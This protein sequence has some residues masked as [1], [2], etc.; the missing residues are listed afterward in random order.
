MT[1]V[2]ASLKHGAMASDSFVEGSGRVRTKV[3]RG[4]GC[5]AAAS[6]DAYLCNV[7]LRWVQA[8][9]QGGIALVKIDDSPLDGTDFEGLLLERNRILVFG[10]ILTDPDE[11][12]EDFAAIGS[13]G[14]LALGALAAGATPHQAVT[15]ACR[16]DGGSKGPVRVVRL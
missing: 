16:W 13:G 2:V 9:R 7:F 14:P 8:G 11:L 5:L 3:V 12:D 6:G 10:R 4:P 15:I 1:T